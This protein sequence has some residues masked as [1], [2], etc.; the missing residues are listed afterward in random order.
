MVV[1]WVKTF[2]WRGREWRDLRYR[3]EVKLIGSDR[4]DVGVQ[5]ARDGRLRF[6]LNH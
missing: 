1:A 2:E 6:W 4:L 5:G 3:P